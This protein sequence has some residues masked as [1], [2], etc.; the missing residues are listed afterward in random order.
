MRD[1]MSIEDTTTAGA[2]EALQVGF[3]ATELSMLHHATD[4]SHK[5]IKKRAKHKEELAYA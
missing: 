4:S 3:G 1:H 2:D 5:K